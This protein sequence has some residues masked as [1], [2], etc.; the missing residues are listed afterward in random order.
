MDDKKT[1]SMLGS[2]N[3]FVKLMVLGRINEGLK[4]MFQKPALNEIDVKLLK[5]IFIENAKK[6]KLKKTI[7]DTFYPD[8]KKSQTYSAHKSNIIRRF[9][10]FVLRDSDDEIESIDKPNSILET[11][12]KLKDKKGTIRGSS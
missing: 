1:I 10:S 8:T 3:P 7:F 6:K 2:K 12:D 9:R 4:N 11:I 5:G